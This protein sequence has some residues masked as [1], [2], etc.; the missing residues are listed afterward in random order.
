MSARKICA[1]TLDPDLM[2]MVEAEATAQNRS[3]SNMV[4]TILREQLKFRR[5]SD[6]EGGEA[7]S[8][9]RSEENGTPQQR[10]PK[11]APNTSPQ[12]QKGS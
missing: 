6:A 12:N 9:E 8:S 2:E 7:G 4:E 3:V 11:D 5:A 1:F 10:G